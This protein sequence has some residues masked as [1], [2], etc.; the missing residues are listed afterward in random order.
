MFRFEMRKHLTRFTLILVGVM[1][2]VNAGL[3]FA[4]CGKQWKNRGEINTAVEEALA[5]YREDPAAVVQEKKE[6]ENAWQSSLWG[7][8]PVENRRVDLDSYTDRQLWQSLDPILE[9][10]KTYNRDVKKVVNSAVKKASDPDT[11]P[12]SYVFWYQIELISR[13][14]PLEELEIP[15]EP[16]TGWNE[17]FA[18]KAP[19]ILCFLTGIAVFS[20]VWLVEKRSRTTNVLHICKYG[21]RRLIL[22][23]LCVSA[24]FS[25]ILTLLFT[26]LPLAV[27][28]FA[29]GLGSP[30]IPMQALKAFEFCP[31]PITVGQ[32]LLYSV[33][34]QVILFLLLDLF[35]VLLGQ[36]LSNEIPVFGLSLL[37]LV[38]SYLLTTAETSS[39]FYNLRQF[40]FLDIAMGEILLTRYRS[41]NFFGSLAGL[42][43]TLYV[44]GALI[45]AALCAVPFF[46]GY[47]TGEYRRLELPALRHI[48][49][50]EKPSKLSD[51]P[52][53]LSVARYEW[54]KNIVNARALLLILAAL[55]VKLAV[56]GAYFEPYEGQYWEIY[57]SYMEDL[58]GPVTEE[59]IAYIENEQTYVLTAFAD[60]SAAV[61]PYRE[62]EID[63]EAFQAISER[64]NYASS[65][66]HPL[67]NI[68]KRLD[69]LT[70][71]RR[72]DYKNLEFLDETGIMRLFSQPLDF[73]LILLFIVLFSDVFVREY[74]TGFKAILHTLK[75]GGVKTW[76]SKLWAILGTGVFIWIVFLSADLFLV[77]RGWP[78]DF[79][80]AGLMSIPDMEATGWQG[81]VF[82]Y[83]CAFEAV[84]FVGASALALGIVS[85]SAVTKKLVL[86]LA[87]S[88]SLLVLPALIVSEATK[89]VSIA[90][91]LAPASLPSAVQVAGWILLA[92]LL[93]AWSLRVWKKGVMV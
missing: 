50:A 7:G 8:D 91:L 76:L 6:Y 54:T 51:K 28:A 68:E 39:P 75:Y 5:D 49:R 24:V 2:A 44:L 29:K 20:N 67:E 26:L 34:A 4:E 65:V 45:L 46:V 1:L 3:V 15:A 52:G 63:Y 43:P 84:R 90:A 25:V 87:A 11:V 33:L 80:S 83:L 60:Y 61:G 57:R 14:R 69:Y 18:L 79:L 88:F 48:H 71:P 47:G 66:E 92:L 23:K 40:N 59:K 72:A 42:I 77:A 31:Y 93:S 56:S 82:S 73:V 64:R 53:S 81:S 16:Q 55:A 74:R 22:V 32:G 78:L 36:V 85:L 62:G 17:Y 38:L 27:I 70:D 9:R 21:G 41:L 12:G 86:Q 35:V 58:K 37:L 30:D 89:G 19:A 13:Y 10:V